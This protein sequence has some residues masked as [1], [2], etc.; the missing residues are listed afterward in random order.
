MQ[1]YQQTIEA[2]AAWSINTAGRY[3]R[4]IEAPD[5]PVDII[6]FRNGIVSGNAN[7]VG[8]GYW[9]RP[10][11][12]FSRIEISSPVAQ[13][14]KI[15][16]ADGDGGYDVVG[17]TGVVG[18]VDGAKD[19]TKANKAFFGSVPVVA[20]SNNAAAQLWNPAGS[21]VDLIV[22]RIKYTNRTAGTNSFGWAQNTVAFDIYGYGQ[23]KKVGSPVGKG[24]LRKKDV[25]VALSDYLS[26]G[27]VLNAS[28]EW[29]AEEPFIVTPGRGLIVCA[30]ASG[31]YSI[32]AFF[33]WFEE[34]V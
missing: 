28:E 23:S 30:A 9:S 8:P 32:A 14:V 33:E 25:A 26:Y 2:G 34:P 16:I 1:T 7:G 27:L 11:E 17:I 31:A 19:R 13:T 12:F 18:V 4:I 21:G 24:E 22:K 3:F 15:A 10:S 20:A 6:F 29:R 5:S